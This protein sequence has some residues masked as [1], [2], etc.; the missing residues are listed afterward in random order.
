MQG[1]KF[2][3]LICGNEIK[4]ERRV[5]RIARLAAEQYDFVVDPTVALTDLRKSGVRADVFTFIQR[6][7]E[8][9]AK[10]P[11]HLEQENL[12]ALPVSTYD[13][14]WN[15]QINGKTRN[16]VRRAEKSGV[17][18]REVP[19]DD[20]LVHGISLIYNESPIRQGKKFWHY[21]KDL[22][23]VRAENGTFRDRAVFIGAFIG[24]QMIGYAKLVSDPTQSQAGL[25][26]ILSMISERDKAP[27]NAM[28]AQAVR[29]CA[30]RGIRHLVYAKFSYGKK[31]RDSLADFK[32]HNGF[33]PLDVP[34]YYIPLNLAGSFALK[35]GLHHGL[36]N[37]FPEWL[38]E[39]LRRARKSWT[40]R[41]AK[42]EKPSAQS[43][44]SVR[45]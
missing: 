38:M 8:G 19:F 3:M 18:V 23:T 21:G 39:N 35:A 27:T 10:Y 5:V 37:L 17:V 31:Q 43:A 29:S 34:R 11:Y 1:N 33:Q 9:A 44:H 24:E 32:L 26:Q 20:A 14:W 13:E 22:D 12:A 16:M 41:A 28:I 6:I 2:N 7:S 4:I 40:S 42:T 15:K 36:A 45:T 30:E 25:M